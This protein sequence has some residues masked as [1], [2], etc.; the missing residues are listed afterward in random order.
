MRRA[1]CYL[2]PPLESCR[3]GCLFLSFLF[4]FLPPFL[5]SY[6][7]SR[8]VPICI[9]R[10]APSPPWRTTK[11]SQRKMERRRGLKIHPKRRGSKRGHGKR[12]HCG[13]FMFSFERS[14]RTGLDGASPRDGRTCSSDVCFCPQ[15]CAPVTRGE[16]T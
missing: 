15:P 4:S 7:C 8:G 12:A 10:N 14:R 5:S 9:L 2:L 6:V 1:L 13:I 11:Q 16:I 3:N